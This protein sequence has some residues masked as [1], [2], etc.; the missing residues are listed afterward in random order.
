M[1]HE[2]T[3]EPQKIV[4]Y[5]IA[6]GSK[7]AVEHFSVTYGS[8]CYL[9]KKGLCIKELREDARRFV[10]VRLPSLATTES[11]TNDGISFVIETEKIRMSVSDFRKTFGL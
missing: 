9:F 7:N 3:K 2:L 4:D 6:F 11:K 10:E 5:A 8:V 1:I